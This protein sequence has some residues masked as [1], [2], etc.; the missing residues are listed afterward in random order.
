M[1]N[2]P[3]PRAQPIRRGGTDRERR[4]HQEQGHRDDPA[5][6]RGLGHAPTLPE[7]MEEHAARER[8]EQQ[9]KTRMDRADLGV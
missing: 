3:P 1:R 5:E 2:S 9:P 4:Q 7:Q 8:T 6:G